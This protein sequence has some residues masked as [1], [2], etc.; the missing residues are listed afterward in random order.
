MVFKSTDAAVDT[1][2]QRL[3]A[4]FPYLRERIYL[5][6]AAAGLTWQ[7]HGSAVARF[8]DEVKSRGMDARPE[9]QATTQRVRAAAACRYQRRRRWT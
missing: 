1:D 4:P 8:Y 9:W 5:D 7:G 6:T 2:T 3:R